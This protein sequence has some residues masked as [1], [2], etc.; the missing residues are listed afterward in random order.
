M[1]GWTFWACRLQATWC[2]EA[3]RNQPKHFSSLILP[4]TSIA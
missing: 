1:R 2:R 3:G 4:S